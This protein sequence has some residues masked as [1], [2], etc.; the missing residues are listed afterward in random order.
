MATE[1]K[2]E[3]LFGR[4]EI[5]NAF[6]RSNFWQASWNFE[7]MHA[8]GFLF[9]MVPF[10]K[11][12]YPENNED[13]RQAM[14]RHLEFFNTQPFMGSPILGVTAAMEEQRRKGAPIDDGAI[15]GL[16][17]GMMGPLAGVGDPIWWGTARPII[18]ALGAGLALNGS[19]LGPILFFVLFNVLRVG[20]RYWSLDY[21][22]RTGTNLIKDMSGGLLQK[23][24]VGSSVL[25]LFI[26]GALVNEWTTINVPLVV[27]R[28]ENP[29]T[30]EEVVTTVQGI[31]DQLIPGL[32]PLLLTFLVMWLLRRKVSPLTIILGIFVVGIVGYWLG[33]L[34]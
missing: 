3:R 22:Y 4:K 30:G 25:G 7:R 11:K 16:K 26:M 28:A 19:I 6:W 31:L 20:F 18:A 34:A 29:E 32:L 12:L 10:L 14:K 9:V 23:L 8:L 21:G 5:N 1:K 33:W 13:R 2:D 17:V 15:N 24:T 27:S